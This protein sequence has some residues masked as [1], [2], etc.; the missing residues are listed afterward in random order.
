MSTHILKITLQHAASA[1]DNGPVN[2]HAVG[3]TVVISTLFD[4]DKESMIIALQQVIE[5]LQRDRFTSSYDVAKALE[6]KS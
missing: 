2:C 3:E 5:R 1:A 4:G 6:L